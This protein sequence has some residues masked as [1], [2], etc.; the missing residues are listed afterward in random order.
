MAYIHYKTT[1]KYV[2]AIIGASLFFAGCMDVFHSVEATHI[3][4]ASRDNTN[5]IPFTWALSR[6]F[7]ALVLLI[8]VLYYILFMNLN[9]KKF[10][11]KGRSILMFSLLFV[12][13]SYAIIHVTARS[14]S[15]SQT[16][17]PDFIITRPYDIIPLLMFILLAALIHFK[18]LRKE[19]GVFSHAMMWCMLPAILTQLHMAFGSSELFDSHFNIAHFLKCFSYIVP[20][21][22]LTQD[23]LRT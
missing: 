5:F 6:L 11:S 13:I 19:E 3:I 1:G 9:E 4:T 12:F 21:F 22:G 2:A 14:S 16:Q 18:F 15:L 17:F 8:G 10:F 23:Y 7:N 20:L